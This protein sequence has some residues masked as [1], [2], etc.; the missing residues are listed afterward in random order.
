MTNNV[1]TALLAA[2]VWLVLFVNPTL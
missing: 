2:S 1:Y